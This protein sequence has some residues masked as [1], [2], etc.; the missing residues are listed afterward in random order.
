MKNSITNSFIEKEVNQALTLFMRSRHDWSYK[1]I[2]NKLKET[3]K[4]HLQKL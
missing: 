1:D 2:N 4:I 3:S